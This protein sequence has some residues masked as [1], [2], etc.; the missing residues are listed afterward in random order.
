MAVNVLRVQDL[1]DIWRHLS[2]HVPSLPFVSVYSALTFAVLRFWSALHYWTIGLPFYKK[3][4]VKF[5]LKKATK[6]QRESRCI[7][8]LFF[9]LDG[10][11]RR[12]V[13]ATPRPVFPWEKPRTHCIGGWVGPRAGLDGCGKSRSQPGF[14][15]W[16]VQ[17]CA[18]R[19]TDCAILARLPFV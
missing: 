10:R 18:S 16:T 8:L 1:G 11:G 5:T 9:N 6:V 7:A 17:P 14:D 12:V 2:F 13:N 19:Y 4:K 15:P 3:R